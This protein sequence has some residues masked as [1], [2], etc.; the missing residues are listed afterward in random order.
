VLVCA[1]VMT[2]LLIFGAG[3]VE[4]VNNCFRYIN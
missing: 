1:T 3:Q 4:N 2:L